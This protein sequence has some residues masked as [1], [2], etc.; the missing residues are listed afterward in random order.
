MFPDVKIDL[1]KRYILDR[2]CP[3][4]GFCHYGLDE[5]N[6]HDTWHALAGLRILGVRPDSEATAR[7]LRSFQE[8]DGSFRSAAQAYFALQGLDMLGATP[9]HDP[10]NCV[11]VLA[12]IAAQSLIRAQTSDASI[13]EDTRRIIALQRQY[14]VPIV[15]GK[16]IGN[17]IMD[18]RNNDGGFGAPASSLTE[19]LP[20]VEILHRLG[21][22]EGAAGAA[23][24][25]RTCEH[26]VSGFTDMPGT[27]LHYIEHIHAG[28]ALCRALRIK[29]LYAA[30]CAAMVRR[31]QLANGGFARTSSGIATLENT[32][33]ALRCLE[34][35]KF[36]CTGD[37]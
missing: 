21:C 36:L 28:L 14:N 33:L 26:P 32:Y 20:A 12:L 3:S 6:L 19:T 30:A 29:P 15:R 18:W 1:A 16:D 24:F 17:R 13:L 35:L 4:G 11:A 2:L 22:G 34:L 25:V 31:C 9:S 23:G 7:F 5:P 37:N 10:T 8:P 27:S